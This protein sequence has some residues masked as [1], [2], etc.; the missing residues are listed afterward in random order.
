MSI[1]CDFGEHAGSLNRMGA[2]DFA[3]TRMWTGIGM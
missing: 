2:Y 1:Y 3:V